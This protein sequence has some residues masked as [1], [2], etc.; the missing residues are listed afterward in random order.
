M[1]SDGVALSSPLV[2]NNIDV[3]QADKAPHKGVLPGLSWTTKED[4]NF[5]L[6]ETIYIPLLLRK[7]SGLQRTPGVETPLSYRLLSSPL[8]GFRISVVQSVHQGT[9]REQA[10]NP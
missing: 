5:S 8:H 9:G 6:F 2:N 1:R 7:H 10:S 4:A 3:F